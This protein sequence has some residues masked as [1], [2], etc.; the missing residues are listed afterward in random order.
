MLVCLKPL[1]S[2]TIPSFVAFV[3]RPSRSPM[4]SSECHA[5]HAHYSLCIDHQEGQW[6]ALNVMQAMLTIQIMIMVDS[7]VS[8]T[9]ERLGDLL[10]EEANLLSGVSDQIQKLQNEL[11]RMQCFLR[12]AERKQDEGG[13]TIKNWISEIKNLAYE[14]E[15]VIEIYA[16]KISLSSAMTPFY[17]LRHVHK[18]GNKILSINSQIA[19]LTRSLQTYGLTATTRDNEESHFVFETRR[20]LRWSYSHV[21]E[22]FIVGL[23]GDIKK[24]VEWLLNQDQRCPM[25]YICGMGGL[26]KT[27]L[28]ENVYHYSSIRRHFECFAWAYISQKC[29]RR[30]VWEGILLQLTTSPS[31]EERDEIRNMRDE[32]LAKKLYKVQQEKMCLIILDDIWSNDAW[33]ILSP[34]F[35]TKNTKSKIIFTSRNKAISSH[36]DPKGLLHE[37]GFLNAEDSWALFQK[38]AFPTK[39]DP[40]N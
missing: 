5:G 31:K 4:G 21:V 38:K 35:P 24:V 3:H 25:V 27:T 12:D 29:I 8:F 6:A 23:D 36:V 40:G 22:E 14:A 1:S 32:E 19:D 18:V 28:A 37:P 30:E 7:I 15:D 9:I 10:I 20:Q 17:K 13:E 33:D 26:G 39:D 11:K 16:I 34:A 2:T